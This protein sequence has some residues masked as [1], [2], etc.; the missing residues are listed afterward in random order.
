MRDHEGGAALHHLVEGGIDLG[1]GDGVE[2]AGCLVEDQDRRVLQQR[3]GDRQALP[4]AAGQHAAAFAGMGLEFLFAALDEFERLRALSCDA[5]FL[6]GGV[7]LADAQIVGERT[8]E[9]QR[10][11]EHHADVTPQRGQLQAADIHAVDLD[12]A[13]LR[14]ESTVQQRDRGGFAGAGRADQRDGLAGERR[15]RNVLDRGPLAVIGKRDVVE[16]DEPGE[17]TGVHGV[18][19]VA[20]CGHRVQHVEEFL[21]A[22]RLHEH[23]VD[24]AHHL[25][26]LLDQHGRKT[27][28][29]HDLADRGLSPAVQVDADGEDREHGD[30]GGGAGDDG[31]QRPPAQYRH[32]YGEQL[33]GDEAQTLNFGID[34]HEALHQRDVAER[35][36]GARREIAVMRLDL[37]LH[38]VG[39]AHHHRR[40][41][42][43]HYAQREQDDRQPPV[44]VERERQQHHQ[45][46]DRGKMLAEESEPEPPQR[47]GAVQHHLHQPPGMG[48]GVEGQRQLHDVLEIVGQHR[49]ALAVRQ[50]VGIE[51]DERAARDGE[52]AERHPGA[53]QRPGRIR[54][55]RAGLRLAGEH[56]DDLAEQHR[57]GELR[58]GQQQ[59]GEGQNPAQPRLLAEQLE[60][61]GVKAQHGHQVW[62]L[63]SNGK[64]GA[65]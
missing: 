21:Q 28:E 25:F 23:A 15:K 4:L 17:A 56:V 11:L 8:V 5:H 39:L 44:D 27:H 7:R 58:A 9:Q 60:H 31:D 38:A 10:L 22:R 61:A 24:E 51:R 59:I 12:D 43:E 62:R 19:P 41:H 26:E 50:L 6:V 13:G 49:L 63:G 30:G 64:R 20:H 48:A 29:H 32:L 52:Q 14:I 1:L 37:A 55:Q 57:L 45:R 65:F 47:V 18:G 40:Q 36:G 16:F 42:G 46:Q 34:P 2:R 35:V 53:Q 3:A 54:G 33:V